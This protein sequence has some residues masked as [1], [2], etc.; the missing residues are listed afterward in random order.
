MSHFLVLYTFHRIDALS[1]HRLM[2]LARMNPDVTIVPVY[3]IGFK[4]SPLRT[5]VSRSTGYRKLV[6]IIS[7]KMEYT[8]RKL[9][10]NALDDYLKKRGFSLHCD[11][12]PEGM[13]NQ[14]LAIVNWYLTQGKK[15]DFEFLIYFEYDIFTTKTIESLY[16]VY[17]SFDAGFVKY[18][19]A[20]PSWAHY[21]HPWGAVRSVVQWLEHQ[22]SSP[23]PYAGFF[24][25][26]MIS[27]K[28]LA[29]LSKASFPN[30]YCEMRLPSVLTGLGFS[31]ASLDFPMVKY[32]ESKDEGFS[33]TDIKERPD[34]GIFHPV[35]DDF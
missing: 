30:A 23:I 13:D 18:R 32:A 33:K 31:C 12:T 34:Y 9:E 19:Q 17:S 5:L 28:A 22:G 15:Y 25:G 10:I 7:E 26:N 3:G 16:D 14:D 8:R 27:R 21:D 20:D 1:L 35:Y 24:P 2:R 29:C 6:N 4:R 11:F